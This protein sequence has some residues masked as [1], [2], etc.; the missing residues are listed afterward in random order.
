MARDLTVIVQE[1]RSNFVN[2]SVIQANYELTPGQTF[3][4]QFSIVS[5]EALLT[6]IIGFSIWGLEKIFDDQRD[7]MYQKE[8]EL[9]P[10]NLFSLVKNAKKF[11]FGDDLVFMDDQ[12]KYATENQANQLVKLASA[13]E[14]GSLV[15]LKI[16]TL[17]GSGEPQQLDATSEL[18]F[19]QYIK[20]M[21]PP[22][23]KLL[24]V[25]RPAD[26]LKIY[27]KIYIN[28]LV[29]NLDGTLLSDPSVR[30]VDAVINNYCK[31]LNFDGIFNVT[32]LTDKIQQ[33]LGVA[34]PVFQNAEAKY[35][36]LPYSPIVDYYN[37]NAGYLRIDPAF[38][39]ETTITYL[40]P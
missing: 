16:A 4:Q 30:P 11:Q 29:M 27:F 12:Y 20:K 22:G 33:A 32:E 7:W 28:P 6:Y 5:F 23:V 14:A 17:D 19:Q 13:N 37:P 31:S 39:L 21:K 1:L 24:V 10:W 38:P 18:A 34:N 15:I 9:R 2:N 35:G 26:S 36:L 3:E 25:N 8:L 40:L